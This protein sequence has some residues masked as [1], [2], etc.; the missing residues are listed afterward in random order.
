MKTSIYLMMALLSARGVA[1]VDPA[2]DANPA[3]AAI[4]F[5]VA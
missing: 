2:P 5:Y 4:D 3:P 1:A